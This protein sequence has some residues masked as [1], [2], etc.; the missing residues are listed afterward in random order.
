M[1]EW[2]DIKGYEGLYQISNYGR[3]R[4]LDRYIVDSWGRKYKIKGKMIKNKIN[5]KG[6]LFTYLSKNGNNKNYQ[7]HRLVAE[8]FLDKNDFKYCEDEDLSK[9]DLN[10]LQVNHKDENKTNNNVDNLE[11]CTAKYNIRYG[12]TIERRS[13]AIRGRKIYSLRKQVRCVE[14]NTIYSGIVEATKDI[15]LKSSSPIIACC[16]G[17]RKT[18]GGYHWEYAD[19]D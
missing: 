11:Y 6:Y 5:K 4:S 14:T 19:E 9:I 15:G 7:T 10:D 16:K 2:K 3:A 8:A 18:S 17:R 13:N 1:E 12:T